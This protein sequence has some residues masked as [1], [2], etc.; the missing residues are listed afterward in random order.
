MGMAILVITSVVVFT[1]WDYPQPE[2]ALITLFV[3]GLVCAICTWYPYY[4][5]VR[6][7]DYE[8]NPRKQ[9]PLD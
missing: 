4:K 9:M 6:E 7:M 8:I 2:W 1:S 3:I 5:V